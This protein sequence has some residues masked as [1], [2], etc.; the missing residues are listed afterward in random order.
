MAITVTEL[1]TGLIL[2]V[3][4]GLNVWNYSGLPFNFMGQICLQ[5][6][7]LWFVL[8]FFGIK[9][10]DWIRYTILGGIKPQ[11]KMFKKCVID[12]KIQ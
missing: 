11:Y 5:F 9:A 6:S 1:I 7:A 3:W 2:N 8:S 4:L 10:F 12:E